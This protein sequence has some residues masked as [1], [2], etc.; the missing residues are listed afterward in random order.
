MSESSRLSYKISLEADEQALHKSI[1]DAISSVQPKVERQIKEIVTTGDMGVDIGSDVRKAIQNEMSSSWDSIGYA[2]ASRQPAGS[3]TLG[4]L[5]RQVLSVLQ[6][7]SNIGSNVSQMIETFTAGMTEVMGKNPELM[8]RLMSTSLRSLPKIDLTSSSNLNTIANEMHK[9]LLKATSQD[10]PLSAID[11]NKYV[12]D[13][14]VRMAGHDTMTDYTQRRDVASGRSVT[15]EMTLGTALKMMLGT[16][17]KE[18]A[19]KEFKNQFP[20]ADEEAFNNQLLRRID[21]ASLGPEGVNFIEAKT[22]LKSSGIEDV[23][24]YKTLFKDLLSGFWQDPTIRK[25]FADALAEETGTHIGTPGSGLEVSAVAGTAVAGGV[26]VLDARGI[27]TELM[28]TEIMNVLKENAKVIANQRFD[29]MNQ[30][31]SSIV[32][33]LEQ[34]VETGTVE[35]GFIEDAKE[36]LNRKV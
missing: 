10:A 19:F 5:N 23:T 18:M 33:V 14:L 2:I 1:T 16:G 26:G 21:I 7:E 17:Y 22:D 34:L 28:F 3:K 12:M 20:D 6:N 30:G 27:K 8:D 11:M 29:N 15:S 31:L 24:G 35:E 13:A 25:T 4:D 36:A 32:S 9:I